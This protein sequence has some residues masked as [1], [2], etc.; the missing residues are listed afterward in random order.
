VPASFDPRYRTAL[1]ISDVGQPATSGA[2]LSAPVGKGLVIYSA[3]SLDTQLVAVTPGAAR[4][5]VN[6]LSA[7][8]DGGAPKK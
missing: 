3:L 4:L 2:L 5:I 8:L 1:S 7:G 6:L